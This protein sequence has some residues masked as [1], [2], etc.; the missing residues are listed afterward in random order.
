MGFQEPY[1]QFRLEEGKVVNIGDRMRK[2]MID[3]P[4][5]DVNGKTV[6]DVGCDHGFW[7]FLCAERGARVTGIDRGREI[8]GEYVNPIPTLKGDNCHFFNMDFGRQYHA[9][10][11]H[12]VV[13]LLSLYQH[14]FKNTQEHLPIWYWLYMHCKETLIWEGFTEHELYGKEWIVAANEYFTGEFAGRSYAKRDVYRFIPKEIP[15][16]FYRGKTRDGA[17]GA[18]KAFLY[19]GMRRIRELQYATG[20]EFFPGS[21]NIQ[22]EKPFNWDM[23]YYRFQIYDV[24]NRKNGLDSEW[25]KRWARIY[26]VMY[27]DAPCYAFRFEGEKYGG[28]F[29]E[30]IADRRLRDIAEGEITL[31]Q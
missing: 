28:N 10:G 6:L 18:T 15:A 9:F 19:K 13:L 25:E 4:L 2:K 3:V 14:V 21:L 27:Y 5:P 12:D 20:V 11:M 23:N 7:S 29:V 1:Q 24:K 30:L 31:I 17:G 22:L 8:R 26:P 16:T